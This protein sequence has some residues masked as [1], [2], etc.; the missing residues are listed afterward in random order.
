MLR[1]K[2][3]LL[4]I[5]IILGGL[6]LYPRLKKKQKPTDKPASAKIVE[7]PSSTDS[8]TESE[9]DVVAN[10]SNPEELAEREASA[11]DFVDGELVCTPLDGRPFCKILDVPQEEGRGIIVK[12]NPEA[13]HPKIIAVR[14]RANESYAKAREI[15]SHYPNSNATE[16]GFIALNFFLEK[17]LNK[18]FLPGF[19]QHAFQIVL[20]ETEADRVKNAFYIFLP[21][22]MIHNLREYY[23]ENLRNF[24]G[25]KDYSFFQKAKDQFSFGPMVENFKKSSP[26]TR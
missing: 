22:G 17:A 1:N 14:A 26:P 21:P 5:V 24:R 2:Y 19:D 3:V 18:E 12:V 7:K 6:T 20:E 16:N 11:R 13:K 25:S 10:A 15:M 8:A 23:Q 4:L 9:S